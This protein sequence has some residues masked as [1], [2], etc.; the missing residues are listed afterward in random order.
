M[1]SHD[2]K[3]LNEVATDIIHLHSQHLDYYAGNYDTFE[4]TKTE[5]LK[6]QRKE[7]EAQ[8]QLREHV[9]VKHNL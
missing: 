1:V 5:K 4:K 2:R 9:Q 8:Q 3:F 6:N 7:Y